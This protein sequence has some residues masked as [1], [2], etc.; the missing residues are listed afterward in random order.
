M[1]EYFAPAEQGGRHAFT[2]AKE[3]YAEQWRASAHPVML[4][5]RTSDGVIRWMNVSD[6]LKRQDTALKQVVF[7]GEPFT[8]QTL[9]L[10]RDFSLYGFSIESLVKRNLRGFKN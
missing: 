4:V 2:I 1:D 5:T 8:A 6:Y 9:W 3:N 7:D 10:M